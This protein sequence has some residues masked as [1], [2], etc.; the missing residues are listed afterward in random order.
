[1]FWSKLV[2][3]EL[4]PYIA[5]AILNTALVSLVKKTFMISLLVKF[6]IDQFL[7]NDY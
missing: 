5:I 3:V 4:G 7:I 6:L 1:M 2:L